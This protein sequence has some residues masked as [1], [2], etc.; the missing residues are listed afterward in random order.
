MESQ[1]EYGMIIYV[2]GVTAAVL[3]YLAEKIVDAV[4][5]LRK[6]KPPSEGGSRISTTENAASRERSKADAT[7]ELWHKLD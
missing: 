2:C 3:L 6:K 4:L 1:A 5:W 7:K